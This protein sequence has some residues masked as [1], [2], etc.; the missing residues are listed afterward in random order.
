MPKPVSDAS[1][2]V[3]M[4]GVR[5]ASL[6]A[7]AAT[8]ESLV[9]D[10]QRGLDMTLSVT[11]AVLF[12]AKLSVGA[13]LVVDRL[14]GGMT[15]LKT[16]HTARERAAIAVY[17]LAREV[18]W[19]RPVLFVH[20]LRVARG[21]L[22]D[23]VGHID[24]TPEPRRHQFTGRL[25]VATVLAAR[26]D[27]PVSGDI[28]EAISALLRSLEQ[29]NDPATA[30]PYLLEAEALR[31]DLDR[32]A[33][34]LAAGM[35]RAVGY[36]SVADSRSNPAVQLASCDIFLR[37]AS[38][39][40]R[41]AA[42][43]GALAKAAVCVALAFS[44]DPDADDLVRA[45]MLSAV[46]SE[47]NKDLNLLDG[48]AVVGLRL[49]FG[50]RTERTARIVKELAVELTE[51]IIGRAL[52]G[53]LL[54]RG[55]CADLLA[56]EASGADHDR[57]RRVVEL[58]GGGRHLS[59]L[60]DERSVLLGARDALLLAAVLERPQDRS[61]QL[62]VLIKMSVQ[63]PTAPAPVLLMAQDVE[64]HGPAQVT[65][66]LPADTAEY[67]QLL[68]DGL[69]TE[70]FAIAAGRVMQS[71]DLVES[72]LGG[73][74]E[75][76]TVGDYY[77]LVSQN[78]TIKEVR[79]E[80]LRRE[81]ERINY[82]KDAI[83]DGGLADQFLV[84][85]HLVDFEAGPGRRSSVRRFV[86]G[87]PAAAAVELA[88]E[89][90]RPALLE[91]VAD[92]L[93]FMNRVEQ[94]SGVGVRK[95]L[96]SKEVGWWLRAIGVDDPLRAFEDWWSFVEHVDI[97]RRRDAHLDNWVLTE[98]GRV[99][100]IDLEAVG[101]R[102]MGYELAQVTDDSPVLGH[103]D[104]TSRRAVFDRYVAALGVSEDDDERRDRAWDAY[105]ASVAARCLRR[106]TWDQESVR[107][108]QH[109]LATLDWLAVNTKFASLRLWLQSVLKAWR[110]SRGLSDLTT[111]E[112]VIEEH[113]RRRISKSMAYHLR[114]GEEVD[115][116]DDGWASIME[117]SEAIG[118][119]VSEHEISIVASTLSDPRFEFRDGMVRARYG[120]SRAVPGATKSEQ[121][122]APA[123]KGYHGTTISV[124]RAVIEGRQGLRPMGR[125]LVHLSR[126]PREA[127]RAGLRHGYPLLLSTTS[128]RSPGLMSRG[129]QTLAVL[130]VEIKALQVEP[131]ATYWDLLPPVKGL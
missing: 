120:H 41:R 62:E 89:S 59:G 94:A 127:I 66:L 43:V 23:V 33:A 7:D 28:E 72:P 111:A 68:R 45:S 53:D 22:R 1:M 57:L 17:D 122:L 26:F 49:P 9:A 101:S 74:S 116:D 42:R 70:L 27:H 131:V 90:Q 40:A 125:L 119:G 96:K 117:L 129:G 3:E 60:K 44:H 81:A 123:T 92:C 31:Y 5:F 103:G 67:A 6:L 79:E 93:A 91:R 80:A 25:G 24:L 121:V 98:D 77:G 83:R 19:R 115:V 50:A 102:P 63:D 14:P 47:A 38:A 124:A 54:A 16:L 71:A 36:M 82:L 51:S 4:D 15:Y 21:Y 73:R 11:E 29:G 84:T 97:V 108:Q 88:P 64:A 78:F 10:W 56:L 99:L 114:H 37:L 58:R 65:G 112:L 32:D 46:I 126:S 2:R 107:G 34:Q 75:V 104:W 48:D 39:T 61:H 105:Q 69:S 106:L 55:V 128:E 113:R 35:K 110:R 12:E 18:N 8:P 30:V 52:A 95:E 85:E 86:P 20:A 130:D 87:T 76:K 13:R 109:A 100:A 118:K